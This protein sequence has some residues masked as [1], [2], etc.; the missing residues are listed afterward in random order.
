VGGLFGRCLGRDDDPPVL[1]LHGLLGSSSN[2]LRIGQAVADA[3]YRVW[4]LDLRNHGRSPCLSPHTYEAMVSDVLAFLD[5][6][7]V[8]PCHVVGHSMGGKVAMMALSMAP[9]R[10]TS[11][12]ILDILPLSYPPY[13]QDLLA[14]MQRMTHSDGATRSDAKRFLLQHGVSDLLADFV[15]KN[16]VRDADERYHWGI[17]LSSIVAGYH[18]LMRAPDLPRQSEHPVQWVM[19]GRSDYTHPDMIPLVNRFFPRSE[20]MVIPD[21]GHWIG[22]EAPDSCVAAILGSIARASS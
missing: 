14:V 4:L 7:G 22:W 2:W 19:G 17:G 5:E 1:F 12:T 3:S 13:H 11:A 21:V 20:L 10:W 18:G 8:G 6:W 9:D 16:W 15:L